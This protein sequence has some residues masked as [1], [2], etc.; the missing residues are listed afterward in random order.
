MKNHY[1]TNIFTDFDEFYN[2][3]TRCSTQNCKKSGYEGLSISEDEEKLYIDAQLP[4]V[5]S[6]EVEVSIDPKKRHLH[7]KGE[8]R[9]KRENVREHISSSKSYSY[10][11]PLSNA[12][13]I[14]SAVHAVSKDG[15]LSITLAKNRSDKPLKIPV[16][17]A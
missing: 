6:G 9:F 4:G 13:D 17:V 3:L 1:L 14:E 12:V 15:I 8:N 7:I 2:A 16:S 11:I 5:N 10:E